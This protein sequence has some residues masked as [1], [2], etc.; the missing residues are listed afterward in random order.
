[1]PTEILGKLSAVAMLTTARVGDVNEDP[2]MAE[3]R[4]RLSVINDTGFVTVDTQIGTDTTATIDTFMIT[5]HTGERIMNPYWKQR[6]RERTLPQLPHTFPV[7]QRSYV[8]GIFPQHRANL[9]F[10]R[11]SDLD[12][13]LVV[14]FPHVGRD[15]R[16]FGSA[17]PLTKE[18]D[19]FN[20]TQQLTPLEVDAVNF[21]PEMRTIV[22]SDDC[23]Q[24]V[25]ND[26]VFMAVI[27]M[28]WGR[29]FWLM[30]KIIEALSMA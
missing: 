22:A 17:V 10:D 20:T 14:M 1:S 11:L 12:G 4:P 3:A 28:V 6:R 13:V 5:T 27:D 2:T 26:S 21:L 19:T 25:R 9:F 24:L 16:G 8:Q 29:K 18:G 7:K 15:V 30:D 23:L